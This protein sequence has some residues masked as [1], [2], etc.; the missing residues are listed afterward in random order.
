VRD[1]TDRWPE[2]L[3]L[4]TS[5][6][7]HTQ[8]EHVERYE[9][10]G[11]RVHGA[12]LD[13]ACGTGYGSAI[14]SRRAHVTGLDRDGDAVQMAQQVAPAT[15]I[16]Q[17]ELP[18]LEFPDASF[19]FVVSF[20]TVEHVDDAAGLLAEMRRVLKPGGA[21]LM[22]TPNGALSGAQEPNPWHVREYELG[23][24]RA[25]LAHAGFT[26]VHVF[27][28]RAPNTE[29]DLASRQVRRIVA[30]FPV[31]CRPGRWWDTM[32]HGSPFVE[33]WDGR[34]VPFFWVLQAQRDDV[35]AA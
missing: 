29:Q 7:D 32:A 24:L 23:E 1:S 18:A 14:L 22:S 28:Q 15:R 6:R 26:A 3:P 2:R 34:S 9:W 25:L 31:L 5:K 13:A 12:V 19:D 16:V 17:A 33:P 8:Q 30:R 21:L 4:P 20:E 11:S 10:A 35:R 27:Q